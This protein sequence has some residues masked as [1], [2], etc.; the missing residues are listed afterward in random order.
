MRFSWAQ[1]TAANA[2][3]F[4]G[5]QGAA[6]LASDPLNLSTCQQPSAC[7]LRIQLNRTRGLLLSVT[8]ANGVAWALV[9]V[10][11]YASPLVAL[12]VGGNVVV[13]WL[14]FRDSGRLQ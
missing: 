5:G 8:T 3:Q 11:A 12:V 13:V 4:I 10:Q 14:V 2:S 9:L 7:T 1:T 6:G